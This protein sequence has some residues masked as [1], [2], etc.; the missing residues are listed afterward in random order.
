MAKV[1]DFI[2]RWAVKIPKVI[3][4]QATNPLSTSNAG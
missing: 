1:G 3:F 2:S 4:P